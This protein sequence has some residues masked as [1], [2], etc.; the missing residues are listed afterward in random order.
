MYLSYCSDFPWSLQHWF[1]LW[2]GAEHHDY[3]HM[4]FMDNFSSS[5]RY[6]DFIFG[7]DER[8]KAHKAK[9]RKMQEAANQR[10]ASKEEYAEIERRLNEESEA[11][12]VAAEAVAEQKKVW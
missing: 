12:G 8:Y 11:I 1:P 7:T 9:L 3:H 4:A 5:F 6:L 10:G 2:A